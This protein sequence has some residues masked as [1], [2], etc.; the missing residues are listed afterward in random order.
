MNIL[1]SVR[2]KRKHQSKGNDSQCH[3]IQT[4]SAHAN[5]LSRSE[6]LN[7]EYGFSD[8]YF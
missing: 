3:A 8:G 5:L 7:I 6:E 2:R 4:Q 1:E